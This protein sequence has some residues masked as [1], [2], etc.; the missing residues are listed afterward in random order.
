MRLR[1]VD[2]FGTV[3]TNAPPGSPVLADKQGGTNGTW[4]FEDVGDGRYGIVSGHGSVPT[5]NLSTCFARID[6]WKGSSHQ[7]REAVPPRA[8][9]TGSGSAFRTA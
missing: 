9:P 7:K 2:N 6:T 4:V 5:G 1:T 3:A 8:A